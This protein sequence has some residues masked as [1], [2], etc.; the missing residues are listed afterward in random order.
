[1]LFTQQNF[2]GFIEITCLTYARIWRKTRGSKNMK[3]PHVWVDDF[4]NFPWTVG[5]VSP[6]RE[7][8]VALLDPFFCEEILVEILVLKPSPE[9]N[10][11]K[12]F[13]LAKKKVP[14]KI[15]EKGPWLVWFSISNMGPLKTPANNSLGWPTNAKITSLLH[16][17]PRD[18]KGPKMISETA[19]VGWLGSEIRGKAKMMNVFNRIITNCLVVDS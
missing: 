5:Y 6:F 8:R 12:R 14:K 7:R 16:F 11:L 19:A 3:H 15:L 17:A 2:E 10:F 18:M 4:R 1:M 9:T 13:I